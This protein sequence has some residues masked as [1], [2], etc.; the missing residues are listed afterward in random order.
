MCRLIRVQGGFAAQRVPLRLP[1]TDEEC[2]DRDDRL[3]IFMSNGMGKDRGYLGAHY[4]RRL[5]PRFM[6]LLVVLL[7]LSMA[8]YFFWKQYS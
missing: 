3:R 4:S 6:R 7:G 8:A 5:N 2:R 1:N